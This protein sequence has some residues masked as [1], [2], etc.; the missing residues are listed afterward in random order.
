M[1]ILLIYSVKT[2]AINK[3]AEASMVGLKVNTKKTY[4][5]I[6]ISSP[7]YKAET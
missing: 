7:E 1:L 5:Y 3:N 2:N 4:V 6:D